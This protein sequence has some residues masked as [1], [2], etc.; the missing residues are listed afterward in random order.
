LLEKT[1]VAP[2]GENAFSDQVREIDHP[3]CSIIKS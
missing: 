3:R 2:K 1:P